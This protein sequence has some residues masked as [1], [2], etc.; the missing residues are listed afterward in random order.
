MHFCKAL[1]MTI[2]SYEKHPPK[3][4]KGTVCLG[5]LKARLRISC[6]YV[7]L[8]FNPRV[9]AA[10]QSPH[11]DYYYPNDNNNNCVFSVDD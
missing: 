2:Y 7:G 5:G 6:P 1:L 11:T 9:K 3:V 10:G 8:V 4:D